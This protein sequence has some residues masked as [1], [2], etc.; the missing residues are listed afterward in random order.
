MP[1]VDYWKTVVLER[2]ATFEGRAR[3]AEFWWFWLANVI[4][5]VVLAILAAAV[6][7]II[8]V[9]YALYGL[10]MII[11]SIAVAIRRLHDTGKTGWLLLLGF[12]PIVGPIVLLVFYLLDSTPGTNQYGTS[13]KYPTG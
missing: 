1:I 10:A 9:L 11:P 3:R 4:V 5:F 2:Y 8:W 7:N 6:S 12:V 13:E